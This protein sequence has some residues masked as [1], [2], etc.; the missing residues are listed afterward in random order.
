MTLMPPSDREKLRFDYNDWSPKSWSYMGRTV[1]AILNGLYRTIMQKVKIGL[2]DK[3]SSWNLTSH[4]LKISP[5]FVNGH[6]VWCNLPSLPWV[7]AH[8]CP[9]WFTFWQSFALYLSKGVSM[10]DTVSQKNIWDI[11]YTL[12]ELPRYYDIVA[13]EISK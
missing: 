3:I 7:M 9:V 4:W 6:P 5:N 11:W 12:F 1:L 2:N 13:V 10:K 8:D